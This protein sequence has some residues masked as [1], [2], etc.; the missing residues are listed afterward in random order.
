MKL[1]KTIS[2]LGESDNYFL[3]AYSV[4]HL[5][6]QVTGQLLHLQSTSG[7]ISSEVITFVL[8]DKLAFMVDPSY[9][10]N[11]A[12]TKTIP[13]GANPYDPFTWAMFEVPKIEVPERK[14]YTLITAAI[15]SET[16]VEPTIFA[17]LQLRGIVPSGELWSLVP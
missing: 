10:F 1:V 8:D 7:I 5:N 9:D 16:P 6:K 15:N 3:N 12:I 4:D 11:D 14:F 17:C 13:V 2:E